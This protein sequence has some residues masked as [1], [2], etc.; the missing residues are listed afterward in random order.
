VTKPITCDGHK[1]VYTTAGQPD[2]PALVM[3]HGWTSY[4]GVWQKTI[5]AF[6]DSHYCVAMDLLGFGDSDKPKDGDYSIETQG[7]RVLHLADTLE[8]GAFTL[9]GHS[10]GGQITLCIASML[11]PDRVAKL[12]SV[13]GVVAARLTPVAE[14]EGFRD[15]R[16]GK[17]LP[18][19]YAFGHWAVRKPSGARSSSFRNWFYDMDAIPYTDWEIDRRMTLQ[20][21]ARFS[22]SEALTAI[23]SLDLTEHLSKIT[24]P[25]L[26]IFGQQDAIVPVNDGHLVEQHVPDSHLVLIDRCGH[27]PMYE[28]TQQYLD[29]VRAFLT[30]QL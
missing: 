17:L 16:L 27:F 25:T 26:V 30:E 1:L 9:I 24:C 14:R 3:I 10:M 7:R 29:T 18:F 23:Y 13:S 6:E 4:H 2:A 8:I 11:A 20:T 19:Y 5:E 21:D 22:N 12:I 28:R 15:M